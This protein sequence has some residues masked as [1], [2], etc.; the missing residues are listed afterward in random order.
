MMTIFLIN[1]EQLGERGWI[2]VIGKTASAV[3]AE[4]QRDFCKE[5][6]A[7]KTPD[8]AKRSP[9]SP[10]KGDVATR[11]R[12]GI[13]SPQRKPRRMTRLSLWR[14]ADSNRRPNTALGGF[15]HVY[16]SDCFRLQPAGR[17][18][19]ATTYQLNLSVSSTES[20]GVRPV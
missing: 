10:R 6:E 18:T 9:H 11:Q 7:A 5:V 15:L 20:G 8:G 3:L 13:A 14:W 1:V 4:R 19:C 12:V 17:Q 16:S 2:S